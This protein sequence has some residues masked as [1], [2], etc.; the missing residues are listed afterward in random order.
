ME[1]SI[2]EWPW[3]DYR[4]GMLEKKRKEVVACAG[5][6]VQVFHGTKD[7]VPLVL[8]HAVHGEGEELWK[9]CNAL[10]CPDF[11]LAVVN[12]VDWNRDM[13]PWAIPPLFKNDTPLSGGAD[14]YLAELEQDILPGIKGKLDASPSCL[15]IA[16]YSLAG[17]FA[18]YAAYKTDSFQ[19]IVSASG[20]LWYP[21]LMDYVEQHKISDTMRVMYFSL[22]DKESMTRNPVLSTVEDQTK[23]IE[24]MMKA[25]DIQ[26]TFVLNQGNHYRDATLRTA[27]GIKWMLEQR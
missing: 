16:G 2:A 18:L 26:T 27:K 22:G 19:R 20:S 10:R 8:C 13:S 12:G 14:A 15:A 24:E 4:E 1:L 5:K 25:K 11:S 3:R 7:N 6:Q 21:K 23:R 9:N 17:L